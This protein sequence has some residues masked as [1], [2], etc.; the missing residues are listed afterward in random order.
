M[1]DLQSGWFVSF[2]FRKSNRDIPL[3]NQVGYSKRCICKNI[4]FKQKSFNI[5]INAISLR[6]FKIGFHDFDFFLSLVAAAS[7]SS[8]FSQKILF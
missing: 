3:T 8:D 7:K 6:S 4:K 2:I 5:L 1:F